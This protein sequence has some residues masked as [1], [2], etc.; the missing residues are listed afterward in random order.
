MNTQISV[1]T[2]LMEFRHLSFKKAPTKLAEPSTIES[3][4]IGDKTVANRRRVSPVCETS[5]DDSQTYHR[6]SS[7]NHNGNLLRFA[8]ANRRTVRSSPCSTAPRRPRRNRAK[9]RRL[10]NLPNEDG[11]RSDFLQEFYNDDYQ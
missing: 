3:A 9:S 2:H 8:Q 7:T 4:K 6:P 5:S 11:Y 10:R 1:P